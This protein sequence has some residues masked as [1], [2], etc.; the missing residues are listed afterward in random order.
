MT[1]VAYDG[2]YIACDG[3]A[4]SAAGRVVSD[5]FKKY[6]EI[7]DMIIFFSG[8]VADIEPLVEIINE[9]GSDDICEASLI[10][11]DK[12]G[13]VAVEQDDTGKIHRLPL[14]DVDN[15]AIGSGADFAISAMDLG[16]DAK[17]A[18]SYA[19]TRD[20]YSGGNITVFD[21]ETLKFITSE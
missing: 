20:V 5:K 18:V 19:M 10:V 13:L 8:T 14:D 11:V 16:E 7:D 3:R 15:F 12:H 6:I 2:R 9:R 1:T 17:D 21:T 4:A